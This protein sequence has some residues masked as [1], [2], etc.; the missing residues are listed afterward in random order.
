MGYF[1]AQ[2]VSRFLRI[3]EVWVRSQADPCRV[4]GEQSGSKTIF[5]MSTSVFLSQYNSTVVPFS[6]SH[7]IGAV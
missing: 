4:F 6:F 7:V 5:S 1:V 3:W 2:E